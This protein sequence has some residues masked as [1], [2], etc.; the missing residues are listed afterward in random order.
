M[1][2]S[3]IIITIF[4][5]LCSICLKVIVKYRLENSSDRRDQQAFDINQNLKNVKNSSFFISS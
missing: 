3:S 5:L 1:R 4:M 2:I